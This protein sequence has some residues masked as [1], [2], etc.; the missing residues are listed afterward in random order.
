MTGDDTR[1]L[2]LEDIHQAAGAKFG[3]FAG[4]S[5]PLTYPAG[6]MKEHLH[7]R[8]HAGLFDIS[9][10]KL[11]EVEGPD[12]IAFLDRACPIDAGALTPSQSKYTLLLDER[13]G[14]LDD[15]IVTRLGDT[16]FMVVANAGNA[17]ADETHLKAVA[18][19]FDVRVT[20][21][22]RVFLALQGPDAAAVLSRA[23]IEAGSLK[24]V[25]Q[26]LRQLSPQRAVDVGLA[27]VLDRI[28]ARPAL[29]ATQRF[30]LLDGRRL[31]DVVPKHR[32]INVFGEAIDQTK[33]F[34]QGGS[35][36]EEE[37]GSALFQA[38]EQGIQRPADPEVLLDIL[39]RR[40]EA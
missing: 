12:A 15:L 38:I 13:A 23:G 35:T 31:A 17:A 22:D 16:R 11:F 10:M 21:L 20:P 7:V 6:V 30:E 26:D 37:A 29:F 8:E 28:E 3:P 24:P 2:P 4:W 5:M 27:G 40:A 18:V 39:R 1:H 32:D 14:I 25:L 36:F 33:P 9:H 19:G 34:G